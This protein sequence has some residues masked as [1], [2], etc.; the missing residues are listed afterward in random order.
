VW[1]Q[2]AVSE[3]RRH[4]AQPAASH[5]RPAILARPTRRCRLVERGVASQPREERGGV[6]EAGAARQQLDRRVAAVGDNDQRA[7]R[8]PAPQEQQR[9]PRPAGQLLVAA[10]P[11]AV[12][13][14]GGGKAGEE[15]RGPGAPGPGERHQQQQAEPAQPADLDEVVLAGAHR[16]AVEAGR[17]D[18]GPPAALAPLVHADD[19]R[20]NG[21]ERGDQP[22]QQHPAGRQAGP[23][24]AVE[25]AMVARPPLRLT[26]AHHPQGRAD[27]AP[28]GR[29]DGPGDQH[30][31]V[32]PH[33]AG[34]E[35]REWGEQM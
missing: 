2:T 20:P 26:Q 3:A 4:G 19:Q 21:G 8:E 22:T 16:V 10:T 32:A 31:R 33:P 28:P 30:Q 14:R 15:R 34:E 1:Y 24:R 25:H 5:A 13:P 12:M 35:W 29:E 23:L 9:L 6:R 18:L 17:G 27:G 11:R 7:V